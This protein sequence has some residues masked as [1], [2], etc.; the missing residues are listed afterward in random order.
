MSTP[1]THIT[2]AVFV[3]T[4]VA[5]LGPLVGPYVVVLIGSVWGGILAVS[6][7]EGIDRR[8]GFKIMLRAIIMGV[9]FSTM[10]AWCISNWLPASWSANP[11]ILLFPVAVFT[12]WSTDKLGTLRD[13]WFGKFTP[14]APKV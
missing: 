9:G 8:L 12:G 14:E 10:L 4:A 6:T 2:G 5:A 7:T 3:T 11:D 1:E 13:R